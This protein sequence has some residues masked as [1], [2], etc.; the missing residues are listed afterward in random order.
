MLGIAL[1]Q[2]KDEFTRDASIQR[3]KYTFDLA[4]KIL[5]RYL[6]TQAGIEEYNIK[7][8]FRHAAQQ[9]LINDVEVWF[10]FHKA[11]NLTSHN[12]NEVTANETYE[13]AQRFLPEVQILLANLEQAG[14]DA[15]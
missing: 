8:V 11:R 2:P 12:S 4:C 13:V 9:H 14:N 3:F 1:D 6:S 7:N 15:S 5:M 10:V